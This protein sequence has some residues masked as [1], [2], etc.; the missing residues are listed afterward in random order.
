M[1]ER[2]PRLDLQSDRA[3]HSQRNGGIAPRQ[4]AMPAA[5]V[6]TKANCK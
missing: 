5:G 1:V 2:D 4:D 6:N 3:Q